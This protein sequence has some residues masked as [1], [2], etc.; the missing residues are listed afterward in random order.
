MLKSKR[1]YFD[2]SKASKPSAFPP[3]GEPAP[4]WKFP[5]RSLPTRPPTPHFASLLKQAGLSRLIAAEPLRSPLVASSLRIPRYASSFAGSC[6]HSRAVRA[7]KSCLIQELFY[8]TAW[9]CVAN[10]RVP[11]SRKTLVSPIKFPGNSRKTRK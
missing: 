5:P 7:A 4:A 9:F 3:D 2:F 1:H 11:A 8:G 10:S 6:S